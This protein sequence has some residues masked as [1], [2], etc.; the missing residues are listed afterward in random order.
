[1]MSVERL[2]QEQID[3]IYTVLR[4]GATIYFPGGGVITG[5]DFT[6]DLRLVA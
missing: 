2:D 6:D 1:M 4:L 5:G 3:A